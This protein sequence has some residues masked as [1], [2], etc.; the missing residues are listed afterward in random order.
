MAPGVVIITHRGLHREQAG[1]W[2]GGGACPARGGVRHRF[3]SSGEDAA[4]P[5]AEQDVASG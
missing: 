5:K 4:V 1:G 2:G 3:H